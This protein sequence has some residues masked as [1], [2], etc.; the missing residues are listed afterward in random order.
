VIDYVAANLTDPISLTDL[1]EVAGL[2]RMHFAAQFRRSTGF[3]PHDYL[4]DRRI[5]YARG[6]LV[7][8]DLSLIE[9][10]LSAGF[11]SQAHFSRMFKRFTGVTPAAW[12]A[13]HKD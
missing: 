13:L 11:A 5:E 3:R 8:S 1:A 4:V 9:I 12:R 7:S 2:S 6:L 10:A